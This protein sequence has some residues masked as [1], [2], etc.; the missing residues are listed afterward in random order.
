LIHSFVPVAESSPFTIHTLPYGIFSPNSESCF[1]VGVAIGD[2]IL[3]MSG[4][5]ALGLLNL[6][7]IFENDKEAKSRERLEKAFSSHSLKILSGLGAKN[8][9]RLRTGIKRLLS[10]TNDGLK[11]D[12]RE[13][14]LFRSADCRMTL[15]FEIGGYTDFYASM[16]HAMNVGRLYRGEENALM[17][18]WKHIPIAYNG[19]ASSVVPTG[20]DIRIPRGQIKLPDQPDPIF[21]K[22]SKLDFEVELGFF[23][24]KDSEIGKPISM[25]EAES[26][27]FGLV[28]VN[29]WS[30]R[31]IQAWEY[32]PLGPFLGK[33]F[34]TTI[35]QWVVPLEAFESFRIPLPAPKDPRLLPYL[36]GLQ[37]VYDIDITTNWRPVN[38]EKPL[39]VSRTN[40][41]YLYWSM[42]QQ[43]VHHSSNGCPMRAGDL[44]ASGTI[45]GPAENSWGSLLE[46]TYN[47]KKPLEIGSGKKRSFLDVGDSVEMTAQAGEGAT[48]VGLGPVTGKI[49][50]SL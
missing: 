23:I 20:T 26:Y 8:L 42:T 41:K 27:I 4:V 29:D 35:S 5:C 31:D 46:I 24:G 32:Q 18:N 11:P 19:R 33:S 40:S 34:A 49:L 45:S 15:P 22:T 9:S 6:G 44:L 47:G 2:M 48:R 16:V 37:V 1:R 21:Q 17:P 30:A 36:N 12:I 43:L 3:D 10:D 38:C 13:K 25:E 50:E 28:L 7:K 39:V 14:V